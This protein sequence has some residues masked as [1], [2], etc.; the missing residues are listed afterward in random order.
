MATASKQRWLTGNGTRAFSVAAMA[1]CI[2]VLFEATKMALYPHINIWASHLITTLFVTFM[3]AIVSLVVLKRDELLRL[4]M[5]STE[6]RYRLLFERSQ[7]GAYRT[8]LEGQVLDCNVAFCRIFGYASREELKG[9]FVDANHIDPTQHSRFIEKLCAEKNVTNFEQRIMTKDGRLV[10]VLNSATLLTRDDGT[11]PVIRGTLT[12]VTDLREAEQQNWRQ[13]A[14]VRSSEDAIL[15]KSLDGTI[16]TWNEGAERIYGYRAEEI[17]GKSVDLL[18]PGDHAGEFQKILELIRDGRELKHF[19]T[20]RVKK[21]GEEIPVDL[22][23]SP[24][25]DANGQVVGASTIAR[26][27]TDRKRADELLRKSETQYRLLFDSNPIPMYVFHRQSLRF[28]A[29]NQAAIQRY[30]FS[31]QEF[32]AMTIA[33]ICPAQDIH[34]LSE[35]VTTHAT[36]LQKL[37]AWKHRLKDGTII[38]VE[39]ACHD[40][41][42][43]ET[44][45]MLVAE[46]DVTE[47]NLAESALWRAEEKYRAI[48]EDSVVGIFQITPEG[49]PLSTN[50]AL[51]ELHGYR[52]AEEFMANVRN[53]PSELFV[54]PDRAIDLARMIAK[55]T[56]ARGIELEVYCKD[57]R[58][59]WINLNIRAVHD[60][61]GNVVRCEGTVEDI[62]ERKA[63]EQRVQFLAYH[64][65]LTDLP[66]RALLTDRLSNALARA[67]HRSEKVAL[68][69]L[70]LDR[71]KSINDSFGRIFGDDVLKEVAARLRS[72]T[73]EQDTLARAGSDEFL[74]MLSDLKDVAEAAITANRI[75]DAMK[76][77][78]FVDGCSLG[79]SCSTGISVFPEHGL[80]GE[81]LI[82]NAEA[83]MYSAKEAGRNN[84]RFFTGEMNAE[85]A[86]RLALDNDLRLALDR[87]EFFLVYQPQMEIASGTI[88]GCEALIRWRHPRLGLIPPD[89]FIT[90]AEDNGMILPIGE[91]VLKTACRQAKE[92]LDAGLPAMPIAVNVSAVQFRQES[93][94]EDVKRILQETGVPAQCLELE[95]TESLLLSNKDVVV[96]VLDQLKRVGVKL[97]IDDFGTGYSSLSYLRHFRVNKLK[98]DR[99]FIRNVATNSDDATIAA[100]II[101]MAKSLSLKVIAEGVEGEIQMS[102]L[103]EHGCDEIQGYY[104]SKPI[105]AA[106]VVDTLLSASSPTKRTSE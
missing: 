47:R 73:R 3:C 99:S 46:N 15:S 4:Q 30:G 94:G 23:V 86:E 40:L 43:Q 32:F 14:I 75:M 91:W 58:K 74:I 85:P 81:S 24:V 87:E 44:D 37:G 100:A 97:A 20:I 18:A 59:K 67:R 83:A 11:E 13:A 35:L 34:D 72:A 65:A 52:G 98:I 79:M 76:R 78:F 95:L 45:A 55:D 57:K 92:W 39:I 60:A 106:E 17:I 49:R 9:K 84:I 66:N 42:F 1:F 27:I 102:F 105:T 48:F 64:D 56:E 53:V 25:K 21:S 8:T 2:M 71:F 28:L 36:G 88:I 69:F 80:D 101:G 54:D 61:S 89:K 31:E 12:D 22:T 90:I 50:R 82:K 33:D 93:F 62:T 41:D 26:D 77:E 103:R 5:T 7:T 10:W 68:L 70:D 63:A 29:V 96:E 104:F 6:E 16:E 19:E 38:D 51:A